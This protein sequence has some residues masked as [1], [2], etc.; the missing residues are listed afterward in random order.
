MQ[1]GYP[2]TQQ[3]H[4]IMDIIGMRL[5]HTTYLIGTLLEINH[6]SKAL[7]HRGNKNE[8][9]LPTSGCFCLQA[10]AER[11]G[12]TLSLT[13]LMDIGWGHSGVEVTEN[14][15]RVMINKIRKAIS[16]LGM[17]HDIILLTVPRS[18]YRLLLS[19]N[20]QQ[21]LLPA[22]GKNIAE[23]TPSTAFIADRNRCKRSVISSDI[24]SSQL[25]N[26]SGRMVVLGCSLLVMLSIACSPLAVLSSYNYKNDMQN[27]DWYFPEKETEIN[28]SHFLKITEYSPSPGW[29]LFR[30]IS[31]NSFLVKLKHSVTKKIIAFGQKLVQIICATDSKPARITDR[32]YNAS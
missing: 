24:L 13:E 21:G 15:V 28:A 17:Q 27:S 4:G 10:L 32:I 23:L 20:P 14:S 16:S 6:Q 8:A 29:M 2:G 19:N 11:G 31:D 9:P 7:I 30:W 18:G 12:S 25:K 3:Y 26:I 5:M 22:T 1:I